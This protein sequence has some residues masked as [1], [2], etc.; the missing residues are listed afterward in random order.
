MV[1]ISLRIFWTHGP[2]IRIG[3]R[4]SCSH[5]GRIQ[6]GNILTGIRILG[7]N[8]VCH[9]LCD[10]KYT[11]ARIY[12]Y[13]PNMFWVL[14][15]NSTLNMFLCCERVV[16]ILWNN[17]CNH[18]FSPSDHSCHWDI[19][20]C[21]CLGS[22]VCHQICN[23]SYHRW[24]RSYPHLNSKKLVKDLDNMSVLNKFL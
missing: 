21:V 14:L 18:P 5:C 4:V 23:P 9:S 24:L 15:C 17:F 22:T 8:P 1:W 10:P 7:H 12:G 20:L 11:S 13:S 2:L 19:L 6:L 3:S 16:Y